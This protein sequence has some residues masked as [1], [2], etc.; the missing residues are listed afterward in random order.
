MPTDVILTI[1]TDEKIPRPDEMRI[2]LLALLNAGLLPA[3]GLKISY[4]AATPGDAAYLEEAL[5]EALEDRPWV[6]EAE[7]EVKT[8]EGLRRKL[9]KATPIERYITALTDADDDR[10][11]NSLER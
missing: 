8:K 6:I 1:K 3:T 5:S 7:I 4:V 11:A 2:V 10:P 9:D